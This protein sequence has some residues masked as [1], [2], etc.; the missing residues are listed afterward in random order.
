[1]KRLFTIIAIAMAFV[2]T[3]PSC[4]T[5]PEEMMVGKFR[6][7]E[8]TSD[9]NMSDNDR[10]IWNEVMES[11]KNNTSVE[12]RKDHTLIQ[13]QNGLEQHGTWELLGNDLQLQ[14]SLEGMSVVTVQI[15]ELTNS[16]FVISSKDDS[17]VVTTIK[18]TKE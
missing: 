7:T 2:F 6:I 5:S 16:Y 15:L 8:L 1:M 17:G 10:A 18:Y 13:I 12:H 11:L 9:Q 14:Y 4:E 3:L